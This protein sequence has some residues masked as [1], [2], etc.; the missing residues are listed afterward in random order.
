MNSRKTLLL[1]GLGFALLLLF[2]VL[3]LKFPPDG[4]ERGA[5]SQFV[6]RFHPLVVHL[7]VALVLLVAVLELAGVAGPAKHL[8]VSAG[9]VLALAAASSLVAVA[10]GWLLARNGGYE[11]NIVIR[12]MWGGLLLASALLVCCALRSRNKTAYAVSLFIAVGL[13]AW[14]ADLGGKLTHGSDF[15]TQR[16]PS[17]LRSVFGVPAP[18]Q[19]SAVLATSASP[20]AQP[21]LQ[22]AISAAPAPS[23]TFFTSRVSPIF[24]DKCVQCHGPAKRKG[25]LRLDSF[26]N[27][28][29]GGKH[30]AVIKSGDPQHSELFRRINLARE[31]EHAMPGE[32][33]PALTSAEIKVIELWLAAGASQTLAAS[34]VRGA[35][36]L[37]KPELPSTSD[38]RPRAATIEA[39]QARL[40]IRLVPRSQ[41]P[42]DG[43]ILRTVSAPSRC[44][45]ATLA[46]LKPVADLIVDAELAGTN[47]TDSGM[48]YVSAFSNLRS[49][50]LSRTAITSAGLSPLA[51]LPKLES[52]NLTATAVDAKGVLLLRRRPSLKHLYLFETSAAD[53]YQ[54]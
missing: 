27:V 20:Q 52:L 4:L 46:A 44:N 53:P 40:G 45:D 51:Q 9:F 38:Y 30:G 14:T 7:P 39:L 8:R 41:S 48:R 24:E 23:V 2:T 25:K 6:G 1:G 42:R 26:E 10:L 19:G 16:M 50:D 12:H 17:G 54:K 43:F 18:K 11:G 34:E 15:L 49:I 33:K 22:P 36:P 35:P 21:V 13:M 28:M 37:P 47:V 31:D 32:G 5:L 29:L 3:A